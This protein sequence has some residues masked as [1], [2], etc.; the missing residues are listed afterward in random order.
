[1]P[2][3]AKSPPKERILSLA[4][5]LPSTPRMLNLLQGMLGN[6]NTELEDVCDLLK[7]DASLSARVLRVSNSSFYSSMTPHASLEEAVSCLGFDEVRKLVGIAIA[8]QFMNKD[9]PY[10]SCTASGLWN[11]ALCTAIAM[12]Y[13]A[14]FASENPRSAYTVGLMRC[15]GRTVLDALAEETCPGAP[16]IP[17]DETVA[18]GDWENDTFGCDNPTAT[19]LMLEAWNFPQDCR[20]AMLHH[21]RPELAPTEAKLSGLLNLACGIAGD[22]GYGMPGES[23][24][25]VPKPE[26]TLVTEISPQEKEL[27]SQA[28]KVA[29]AK[30][31]GALQPA[32]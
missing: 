5:K 25:W 30:I 26:K 4:Q 29:F 23:S 32:S 6:P 31:Q 9:L 8:C 20:E 19:A 13:L 14:Q 27:C 16:P 28:T 2:M 10:Y 7:R 18:L 3:L 21:Y 24:Y 17:T 1:M 15:M 12:E 22:L 11:N